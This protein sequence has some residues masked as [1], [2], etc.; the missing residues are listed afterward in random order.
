MVRGSRE[1]SL[2][3]LVLELLFYL[4]CNTVRIGG[5]FLRRILEVFRIFRVFLRRMIT[6][7]IEDYASCLLG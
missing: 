6:F 3:C 1:L 2:G 7:I 5:F 4:G